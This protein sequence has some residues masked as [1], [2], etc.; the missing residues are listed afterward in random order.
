M[1]RPLVDRAQDD[2]VDEIEAAVVLV[3]LL[4]KINGESGAVCE[5][6]FVHGGNI[7]RKTAERRLT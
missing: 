2:H 5:N 4:P 6:E 3:V 7:P 1:L